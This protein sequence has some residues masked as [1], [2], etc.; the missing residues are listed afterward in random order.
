M[1]ELASLKTLF[2]PHELREQSDAKS[3][4]RRIG[5]QRLI[6]I[7]AKKEDLLSIENINQ[8]AG[9]TDVFHA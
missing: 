7:S 1:S 4:R 3:P 2:G 8:W 6:R 9:N 5:L